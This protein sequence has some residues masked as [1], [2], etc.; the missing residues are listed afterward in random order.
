MSI[1]FHIVYKQEVY[2]RRQRVWSQVFILFKGIPET[3][4]HV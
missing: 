1:L 2:R 4:W 3:N